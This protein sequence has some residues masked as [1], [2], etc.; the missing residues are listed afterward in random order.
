MR[1]PTWIHAT[2]K[3][4]CAGVTRLCK[5]L[6]LSSYLSPKPFQHCLLTQ[7]ELK[8][9]FKPQFKLPS[10]CNQKNQEQ[11]SKAEL[12]ILV[13]RSQQ[14]GDKSKSS[15][16]PCCSPVGGVEH[17]PSPLCPKA[18]DTVAYRASP[19]EEVR[20]TTP[21]TSQTASHYPPPSEVTFSSQ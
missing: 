2:S 18:P 5:C 16:W 10:P 12:S 21:T 13:D 19:S 1:P 3:L 9:L 15:F 4:G 6:Q 20:C 8:V 11:R 7:Y 17:W 14:S